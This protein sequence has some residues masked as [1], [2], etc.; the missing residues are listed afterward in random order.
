MAETNK[1]FRELI[2]ENARTGEVRR[3][4]W[5]NNVYWVFNSDF[6]DG[7]FLEEAKSLAE[8]MMLPH[9]FKEPAKSLASHHSGGPGN[10][11]DSN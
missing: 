5:I 1:L 6:Q 10:N 7:M 9:G 4:A 3:W 2:T 8:E 11:C